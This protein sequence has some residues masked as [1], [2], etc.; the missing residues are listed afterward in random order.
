MEVVAALVAGGVLSIKV[1]VEGVV[2]ALLSV[3]AADKEDM[4]KL[5]SVPVWPF[6]DRGS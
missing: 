6:T 1:V 5:T 4:G 2:L 3:L